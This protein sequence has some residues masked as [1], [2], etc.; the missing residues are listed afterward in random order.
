MTRFDAIKQMNIEDLAFFLSI[1]ELGDLNSIPNI[2]NKDID[3]YINYLKKE[4]NDNDLI[5]SLHKLNRS[6]H[7]YKEVEDGNE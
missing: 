6:R 5:D 2:T 4:D 7:D 1:V 3:Y